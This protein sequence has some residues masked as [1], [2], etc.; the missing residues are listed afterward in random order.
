MGR[1]VGLAVVGATDGLVVGFTEGARVGFTV[2]EKVRISLK[3]F[4]ATGWLANFSLQGWVV[5]GG[6]SR[7]GTRVCRYAG[8]RWNF[9]NA[10]FTVSLSKP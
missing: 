4:F 10:V 3:A 7:L 1:D 9:S 6:W 2:G 8:L 5:P